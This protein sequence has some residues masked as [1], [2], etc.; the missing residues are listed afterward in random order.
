[1][2]FNPLSWK[3]DGVVEISLE[4]LPPNPSVLDQDG[5]PVP[6]QI[7]KMKNG[8]DSLLFM[9]RDIPSLGY[10]TYRIVESSG[11]APAGTFE[12]DVR[13]GPAAREFAGPADIALVLHTS[14]TTSR[15]KIVPLSHANLVASAGHIRAA[16]A[17]EPSDRCLN[18]MPLFHIHGLIG[19]TLSTIAAG[20][21]IVCTPGFQAPRFFEIFHG[22]VVTTSRGKNR[23][24]EFRRIM[25]LVIHA[26]K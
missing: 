6:S 18:V 7:V 13:P 21:S 2:L 23:C 11:G 9:A 14:G 1:M 12:L 3:R 19:A 20:G 16:L 10:A 25:A 8:A 17:L 4:G 26:F 22:S 24:H 15:P 5:N